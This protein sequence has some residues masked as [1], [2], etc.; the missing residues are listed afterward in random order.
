[1][2][3]IPNKHNIIIAGDADAPEGDE[4]ARNQA[5]RILKNLN[6]LFG[7]IDSKLESC[8]NEEGAWYLQNIQLNVL[9][10]INLGEKKLFLEGMSSVYDMIESEKKRVEKLKGK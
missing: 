1:M 3:I 2:E 10:R 9:R 8:D 4:Y 7:I 6:S 5:M